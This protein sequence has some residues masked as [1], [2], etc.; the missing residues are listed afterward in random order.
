MSETNEFPSESTEPARSGLDAA[1]EVA[2]E[3]AMPPSTSVAGRRATAPPA[4]ARHAEPPADAQADQPVDAADQS[5]EPPAGSGG[6]QPSA[7]AS[8]TE[9]YPDSGGGWTGSDQLGGGEPEPASAEEPWRLSE[10]SGRGDDAPPPEPADAR[11]AGYDEPAPGYDEPEPTT[12]EPAATPVH[13]SEHAAAETT[14]SFKA[15]PDESVLNEIE[16]ERRRRLDPANRPKN[17]EVDNTRRHFNP[18]TA[19]FDD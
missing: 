4:P 18:E 19:R 9:G 14:A 12:V 5:G 8:G 13:Q 15:R 16:A 6:D 7:D 11:P 3:V 1:P 2:P 10:S 17:A